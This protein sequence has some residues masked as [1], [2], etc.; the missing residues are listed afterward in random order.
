MQHVLSWRPRKKIAAQ[1]T[2]GMNPRVLT[3][4]KCPFHK[5]RLGKDYDG[6][7]II[8]EIPNISYTT[9]LAGGIERDIS[10]EENF[11]NRRLLNKGTLCYVYK[12]SICVFF[13]Y[14]F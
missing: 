13:Y 6:G 8:A 14:F 1:I 4:Y 9:L 12:K 11:I 10:F 3:V 7:Y 5:L 2:I